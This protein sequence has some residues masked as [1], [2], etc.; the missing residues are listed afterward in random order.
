MFCN[1][2]PLAAYTT[3]SRHQVFP[4]SKH[5]VPST[6]KLF[7]L[8][9]VLMILGLLFL[10]N[11]SGQFSGVSG[12]VLSL[13]TRTPIEGATI[14]LL[15]G[16]Q[17]TLANERGSF[18]FQ[19]V[20]V[21]T[22]LLVSAIGYSIDTIPIE[23]AP[24]VILMEPSII[25]LSNVTISSGT[26]EQF[27]LI[28]KLDIGTR[29]INNSQ[30]V[31][32][33]VPGLFIGQHAGGG[34]AEQIFLRGFDLDHGTDIN[35][36]VDGMPV[37]MVSHAHGQGYAD[38]HFVIPELIENV[39][40]KKGPY[41][42][43]KGNFTT[44]GFVDFK[45]A[46]V[47]SDNLVKVEGGM[48]NTIRGLGMFDLLGEKGRSKNQSAYVA[49]ELMYTGGYFN[50]PQDFN[51]INL[52]GKYYGE[53]SNQNLLS[54]SASAFSSR[55]NASGQI[56]QR[57]VDSGLIGFYGAIDP[58]E[59]GKTSRV[60]IN[61]LL[62]TQLGNGAFMKNQVYYS[63]YAFE[64]YSNFT[65]FKEDPVNGDQIRQKED[66]NLLG[67]NGSYHFQSFLSGKRLQSEIGINIRADQTMN[68]ELSRT[69]D[70]SVITAPLKLGN[71]YEQ[72]FAAYINENLSLTKSLTLNVGMRYDYFNN[73]YLDKLA[74]NTREKAKA[75]IFSPKISLHHRVNEKA[76]IYV[77]SGR[78][79]HSNDTRAVVTQKGLEVLPA[80]FGTDLGTV[81]KSAKNVVINFA[82]WYLF[83]DQEFVY[84]GDEAVV[85]AGG[86]TRRLG[87]D[88]SVRYQPVRWLYADFDLN[89]SYARS[90]D[91]SKGE[92]Y[93]PL[94][95]HF[96]S[97]GGLTF[98]SEL[99]FSASLRYR[100]MDDRPATE[101]NSAIA[102]G[103]LI[104]DGMLQY[105]WK[106]FELG[107]A[108]Q[109]IFNVKWKETQFY[110]ETRLFNEPAPVSEIH[111][112]PGTPFN[113]KASL[114]YKF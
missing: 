1:A 12:V 69:K 85:E 5:P 43:D 40:F 39:S 103:Y 76:Q 18:S 71:I 95:P 51:R 48:F 26:S 57:A 59:G 88:L 110:T 98:K 41:Y 97:V 60:N 83:L 25:L 62:T 63:K 108:I 94:A 80:A 7:R 87:A 29:G 104:T 34:K 65:F 96:T 44:T 6:G 90:V 81:L 24:M 77:S 107:V 54:V 21:S 105:Q 10:L 28:S 49:S 9:I 111:F 55:W 64:L 53:L 45:T 91:E 50:K 78:G 101:D 36:S 2:Q 14:T 84:V 106:K 20:S 112:T 35:I 75:S 32:R 82:A 52:F 67:Y 109:N 68:T 113:A 89:Y 102:K 58:N 11:C 74:G 30:E 46:N 93:L 70:R 33:M 15:P 100:Y 31:L 38:L 66:R 72:N 19:H 37:N 61:S 4:L 16:R 73:T 17:S 56:P 92:N 27:Q 22:S 23:K 79:F 99:P 114:S 86:R 42:A 3:H 13:K 8:K 47:L